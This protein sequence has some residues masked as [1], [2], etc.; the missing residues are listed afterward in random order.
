M[1]EDFIKLLSQPAHA[2][3]CRTISSFLIPSK[4]PYSTRNPFS[5]RVLITWCGKNLRFS[6]E[7]AIYLENGMRQAS[8]CYGMLIESHRWRIDPGHFQWF[9]QFQI[10]AHALWCRTTKFDVV[11]RGLVF[12]GSVM[13]HPKGAWSKCSPILGVPFYLWVCHMLQN[14]QIWRDNIYGDGRGLDCMQ[15][16]SATPH[17]EV[18][19]SAQQ[20]NSNCDSHLEW[21]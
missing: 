17:P 16:D 15:S 6:T 14:Y 7:I 9:M 2:L 11:T 12:W 1:A 10:Y 4:V 21:I 18:H 3:W 5:N 13:P 20:Y 19:P 8:S